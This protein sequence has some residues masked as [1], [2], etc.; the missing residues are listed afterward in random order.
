[1]YCTYFYHRKELYFFTRLEIS[2]Y[3]RI[4]NLGIHSIHNNEL[5]EEFS[6]TFKSVP[7]DS[8][9][10]CAEMFF[11]LVNAPPCVH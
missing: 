11:L 4:T 10:D 6:D 3:E 7:K 5:T 1:M 2:L 8:K 9:N